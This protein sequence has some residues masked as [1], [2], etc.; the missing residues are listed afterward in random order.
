VYLPLYPNGEE[1]QHSLA[2]EGVGGPNSDDWKESVSLCIPCGSN[3]PQDNQI[4]MK[5]LNEKDRIGAG[6]GGFAETRKR[7]DRL[8]KN[9]GMDI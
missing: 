8:E 2:D 9:G 1:E 5:G 6:G 4:K 7:L 3:I